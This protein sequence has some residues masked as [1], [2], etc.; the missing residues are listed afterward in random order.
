MTTQPPGPQ[1]PPFGQDPYAQNPQQP[2]WPAGHPL[3]P[4]PYAQPFPQQQPPPGFGQHSGHVPMAP[5][6]QTAPPTQPWFGP[7]GQASA[8]EAE[9]RSLSSAVDPD[10]PL[11]PMGEVPPQML[12]SA[13]EYEAPQGLASASAP[14]EPTPS[15]ATS[16]PESLRSAAEPVD[17]AAMKTHLGPAAS[18]Q[19]SPFIDGIP[20]FAGSQ[21]S[22]TDHYGAP[23]GLSSAN[24]PQEPMS[25]LSATPMPLGTDGNAPTSLSS[26]NQADAATDHAAQPIGAIPGWQPVSQPSA[27]SAP[28]APPVQA[29]PPGAWD[30][31]PPA[32]AAPVFAPPPPVK[33]RKKPALGMLALP[34]ALGL[35]VAG[36]AGGW[37]AKPAGSTKPAPT[38]TVSVTPTPTSTGT[39]LPPPPSG[40]AKPVGSINLA[41][42][43]GEHA[44][45]K[46]NN[47]GDLVQAAVYVKQADP[48]N[49]ARVVNVLRN[50]DVATMSA[51]GNTVKD[52]ETFR[53]W[54]EFGLQLCAAN[55]DGGAIVTTAPEGFTTQADT[56]AFFAALL[57]TA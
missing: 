47:N 26:A 9:P 42:A 16:I 46:A 25:P 14:E 27:P 31:Q 55:V 19:P 52:F 20:A 41:N 39:P 8:P 54:K 44:K 36:F 38:V 2:G 1:Q 13:T 51:S 18:S 35:A 5:A 49:S 57:K 32:G 48:I 33:E 7:Q 21:P 15:L 56:A 53:C 50:A 45:T 3:P 23:T 11:E 10:A 40:L 22:A 4:S 29:P 28:M 37:F 43:V 17:E 34:L 30:G 24:A 12:A 6:P